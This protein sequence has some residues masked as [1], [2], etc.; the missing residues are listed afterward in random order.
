MLCTRELILLMPAAPRSAPHPL[1][2]PRPLA[3]S[4]PPRPPSQT[5]TSARIYS[6][7]AVAPDDKYRVVRIGA[8]L[9]LPRGKAA[10]AL[11]QRGGGRDGG[12]AGGQADSR[13][14]RRARAFACP[15]SMAQVVAPPPPPL[16]KQAWVSGPASGCSPSPPAPPAWAAAS[17]GGGPKAE[18]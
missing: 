14:A 8:K 18:R 11:G 1:S 3:P 9:K 17:T 16:R 10:R 4:H 2:P 12:R 6:T 13:A 5:L 7:F 15:Y